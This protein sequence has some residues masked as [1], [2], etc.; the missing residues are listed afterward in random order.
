VRM[1]E[2]RK[3]YD[4]VA[5]EIEAVR[6]TTKT[7]SCPPHHA[8]VLCRSWHLPPRVALSM[9]ARLRLMCSRPVTVSVDDVET[10]T[11]VRRWE[12]Q[13]RVAAEGHRFAFI[14]EITRPILAYVQTVSKSQPRTNVF[15]SPPEY[16]VATGG[17][18]PAANQAAG[19]LKGRLL[20]MSGVM[21]ELRFPATSIRERL[22]TCIRMRRPAMPAGAFRFD[23]E[24]NAA[25]A[26]GTGAR[27]DRRCAGERGPALP[28]TTAGCWFVRSASG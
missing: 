24:S 17:A 13:Y 6:P 26:T 12:K 18:C 9:R 20:F 5:R 11:L 7:S 8:V 21:G 15:R 2:I 14:A 4:T 10:R 3:H 28:A 23:N 1:S 16:V 27:V 22:K 19:G 25:P